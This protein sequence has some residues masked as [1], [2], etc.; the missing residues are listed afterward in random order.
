MDFAN[1]DE[2]EK[3]AIKTAAVAAS[4]ELPKALSLPQRVIS[5]HM[6]SRLEGSLERREAL[7]RSEELV[8]NPITAPDISELRIRVPRPEPVTD[9]DIKRALGLL[10]IEYAN[11]VDRALAPAEV[12]D[13]VVV[14]LVTYQGGKLV[15][16][17]ARSSL[18][19]TLNADFE[20]PALAAGLVGVRNGEARNIP[21]KIPDDHRNLRLRGRKVVFAVNVKQVL[22]RELID[23][24]DPAFLEETG[25]GES[26]DD[27]VE[28]LR[29][30][31]EHERIDAHLREVQR[32]LFQLL[33]SRTPA[34]T[35]SPELIDGRIRDVWRGYERPNLEQWGVSNEDLAGALLG[36][37]D[38]N[39]YARAVAQEVAY[40]LMLDAIGDKLDLFP[41]RED[42]EALLNEIGE[43][44]GLEREWLGDPLELPQRLLA[45]LYQILRHRKVSEHLLEQTE[46]VLFTPGFETEG[47][48]DDEAAEAEAAA[49]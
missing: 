36:W 20:I 25:L 10:Q 17:G 22:T 21:A 44:I 35:I 30:V 49:A 32:T 2:K 45:T 48:N 31:I 1:R 37:I 29:E 8:V 38:D 41:T 42:M 23:V 39:V 27:A 3:S 6:R 43:D 24:A 7:E 14:D 34:F 5:D 15:P 26:L 19:I 33:L 11:L 13:V 16:E 4:Q 12:G 46:I 9:I 28:V 18:E 40:G 47:E